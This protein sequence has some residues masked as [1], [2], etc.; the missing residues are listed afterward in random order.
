MNLHLTGHTFK[1]A[2]EQ[3]LLSVFPEEKP[4]YTDQEPT[5]GS[6]AVSSLFFED[7]SASAVTRIGYNGK[8][9]S[10]A[11]A[12]PA[13]LPE[14]KLLLNRQLQK[15]IKLSFYHAALQII[16]QP[17]PW[18][19][20]TGIRPAKLSTRY[21]QENSASIGEASRYL[22]REYFVSPERSRLSADASGAALRVMNLLKPEDISVYIGI[23]FCPTRCAYCSFIS[24]SVEKSMKQMDPYLDA[25]F[26]E[27]EEAGQIV[28]QLRLRVVSLY[29]GGGT[30][31][32]LSAESLSRLM[33]KIEQCFDLSSCLEYSV[34]AGRPDTITKE[35]LETI[36]SFGVKRISINPQSM[37]DRVLS[38]IK[39]HHT[40]ADVLK[41]FSLARSLGFQSINMDLIAGLPSDTYEG[42]AGSL[43]QVIGL[44]PENITVHTLSIKRGSWLN[45]MR[46]VVPGGAEVGHML[47]TAI[48]GL[49]NAGWAPYYL[50][51]QKYTAGGYENTGWS[52]PGTD[53]LYNVCIMEE[54]HS[55]IAL[56]A[57]GVTKLVN[58]ETG[59]IQ[60]V[61]NKKYPAEYIQDIQNSVAAKS[62]ITTFIK[63]NR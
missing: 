31:T 27:L 25:L 48:S 1:Y 14:S 19:A 7:G 56:G 12:L 54:L 35:K 22:Q 5:D 43:S 62:S 20:L 4:V 47:D 49:R 53:C 8:T 10:A 34:E 9:G 18:G 32:T 55:I 39:R 59:R 41:S 17:P 36:K 52:M 50:Y 57:G 58:P 38:V 42:F 51:R 21:I 26:L 63:E 15:I 24:Q 60:R 29:I 16:D 28:R 45:E 37:D 30:P 46:A 11:K 2:V 6:F 23:P 3:I 13:P 61:F 40:G 33:E 44:G